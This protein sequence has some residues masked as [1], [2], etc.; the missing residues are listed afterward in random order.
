MTASKMKPR[1]RRLAVTGVRGIVQ[2]VFTISRFH[3]V[4]AVFGSIDEAAAEWERTPELDEVA[5]S[6]PAPGAPIPVRFWGTRGSL[7][8]PLDETAV[9]AKIR[10]ALLAACERGL[11]DA[12]AIDAF[13]DRELPFSVRG[14]FG[15]NTS[16]VEIGGGG[17][18]YLLCDLGTGVREFGNQ[19]I[20]EHGPARPHCFNVF[21]SHVHWDHIMGFP[22]FAPAYIA[23]NRIRIHGCHKTLREAMC[24]SNR[25]RAFRCRSARCPRRS[26]S[27]SWSPASSTGS[28]AFAVS[29]I[30]QSHEGDSYGYRFSRGGKSIV[31][32]TDCEHKDYGRSTRTIRSSSSSATPTW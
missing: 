23:G 2:E 31:Y 5:E 16:C 29:A 32:S 22:F 15:G 8:A 11:A 28:A 27:S 18:D 6:E 9:R 13:I 14:T 12:E 19:V 25:R 30:K 21:L 7:S 4:I 1:G 26:S 20:A 17:D 24:A 10:Q 3:H